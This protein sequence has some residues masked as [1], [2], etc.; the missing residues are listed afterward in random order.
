MSTNPRVVTP[1][2]ETIYAHA[3]ILVVKKNKD[4]FRRVVVLRNISISV[5]FTS[6]SGDLL[7]IES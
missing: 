4:G 3:Q 5:C 2:K 1:D 7:R 6:N